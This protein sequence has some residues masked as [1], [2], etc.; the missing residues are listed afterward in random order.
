MQFGETMR[1]AIIGIG[2]VGGYY[3]GSLAHYYLSEDSMEIIFIARGQHL[4]QIQKNGLKLITDHE[5]YTAIPTVA[6]DNMEK[7]GIIDL[8]IFC[9]KGYD[10]EQSARQFANNVNKNTVIIPLL[11][12]V[13]NA[14]KLKALLPACKIL[15]GCVYIGASIV[16]PG[17]VRQ[18]GGSCQLLFGPEDGGIENFV[19]IEQILK[20]AGIKAELKTN[21]NE[22]VWE[23][24]MF[25][26]PLAS[27]TSL[28]RQPFGAV[29]EKKESS[30]LLEGL[31]KEVELIAR[32]KDVNLVKD[33]IEVSLGKVSTFPYKTK[34]SMQMDFE[35]AKKTEIE[36]FTGYIV[37]TSNELGIDTP[38]HQKV[39]SQLKA[40]K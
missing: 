25:V 18:A 1:I 32:A 27:V 10:L 7:L 38:L 28:L 21:I 5:E 36:I 19:E 4:E 8:A 3:G 26:C 9:V 20:N 14:E 34:S 6:T 37:K 23:K 17:I 30:D 35:K 15:N 12:G 29:M 24:Y 11:N 13:N 2:G 39:Y 40:V 22:I 16:E 33:I 31:M